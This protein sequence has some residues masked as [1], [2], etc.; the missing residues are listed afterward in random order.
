MEMKK[1]TTERYGIE[2]RS[3][4]YSPARLLDWIKDK[5]DIESD[6]ELADALR[7]HRSSISCVRRGIDPIS[8]SLVLDLRD[9]FGV[10]IEKIREIAGMKS[11]F[12]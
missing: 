9:K 4:N 10:S 1:R 3:E 2:M 5:F 6:E 12:E 8:A 11:R 7:R